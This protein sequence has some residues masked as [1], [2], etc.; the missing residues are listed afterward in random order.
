MTLISQT[1]FQKLS[2]CIHLGNGTIAWK[3]LK[4]EELSNFILPIHI[5][6]LSALT[7]CLFE[8]LFMPKVHKC[9]SHASHFLPID[10]M[11]KEY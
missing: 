9:F 8:P 7:K 11:D 4:K 2:E 1:I 3:S 6:F 10:G 5:L